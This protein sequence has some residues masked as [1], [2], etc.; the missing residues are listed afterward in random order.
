MARGVDHEPLSPQPTFYMSLA[1]KLLDALPRLHAIDTNRVYITGL[2]SGGA[3]VWDIAMRF[4]N[5]FAAAAP[6]CGYGD[7]KLA[8]RIAKMPTWT[9]HSSDDGVVPVSRARTMVASLIKAGGHPK[10]FEYSGLGHGCYG[11]AYREP[12]FL[13]WMFA[14]RRGALDTYKLKTPA[15]QSVPAK[16]AATTDAP[17]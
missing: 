9:F 15:P 3:A 16:S 8:S 11:P 2:S 6:I 7:E 10:Y 4:P 17:P 14:Q 12:E 5:R 1:I 13:P